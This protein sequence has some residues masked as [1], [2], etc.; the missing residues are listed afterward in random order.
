MK[1]TPWEVE[2]EV[3]Y[4]KLIKEFGT[5]RIDEGL[6]ERIKRNAGELNVLIRRDVFFSH[7]DLDKVMEDY[8]KGKGFFVY[9]G[10]GPTGKMHIGHMLSFELAKWFQERFGVN[11][12][13]E[14]TDDE[15][16]LH[17]RHLKLEE[18][19][20]YAKDNILDIAAVGFDEDKTFIFRDTE[21]I[22]NV[23]RL[24]IKVAR[25]ITFST[26]KAVFGFTHETNIGLI[27]YPAYQIV[28]TFFEKKRALIPCG[29][30][31]D[32]YWR[33]QRDIAESMGYY[34]ASAIHSRFFPPLEGVK[35][36]MSSSKPH[37]AIWLTDDEKTVE[38]K[39]MKYAFS[40]G[41][42]TIEEHRKYGADLSIDIPYIWL[43]M[44]FEKDDE[45]LREIGEAYR[46]GEMLSG[47][48]K[49]I[50]AERINEYLR[51]HRER[52]KRVEKRIEQFMYK[53]KLAK[54]MW[55]KIYT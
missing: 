42:P 8:E 26:A 39:I 35:G 49:H 2:G 19:D 52:R 6:K 10:R 11:V 16:F 25:K 15:K 14:I 43:S 12:Y 40:G 44:F 28:P 21:Y 13:I 24:M 36:K 31:Q 5:Q 53:G 22:R 32:P 50:L 18:I 7:R 48:I 27:F 29:I 9:T 41:K 37:T 1:V 20:E 46:K 45:K 3:N 23:Y 17:K 51:K 47:E 4:E 38:K 54:E 34:K 33:I 30:D 55:S